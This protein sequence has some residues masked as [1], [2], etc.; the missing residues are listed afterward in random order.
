MHV[1][2]Y[3]KNGRTVNIISNKGKYNKT[4]QDCFFEE[5]VK[6]TDGE[7]VLSSFVIFAFI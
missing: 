7:T 6:A 3:L 5:D 2:L 1:I 4:T